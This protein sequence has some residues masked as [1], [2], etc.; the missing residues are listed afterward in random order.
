MCRGAGGYEGHLAQLFHWERHHLRVLHGSI[1]EVH[2]DV[3][4]RIRH[5]HREL[6][7]D[8]QSAAEEAASTARA[9]LTSNLSLRTS[10]LIHCAQYC[11]HKVESVAQ[12]RQK[13]ENGI[14]RGVLAVACPPS[15]C[16]TSLQRV[17]ARQRLAGRQEPRLR[18]QSD[19]WMAGTAATRFRRCEPRR[20][21]QQRSEPGLAFREAWRPDSL[22]IS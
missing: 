15:P 21:L 11:P 9:L 13:R 3:P 7:Q 2:V 8:L 20:P 19:R 4:G 22:S 18:R 16:T 5:D 6:A 10:Q 1:G 14:V 17:D 12:T